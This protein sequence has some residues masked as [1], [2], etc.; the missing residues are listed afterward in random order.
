MVYD[1]NVT[2]YSCIDNRDNNDH[3]FPLL[4]KSERTIVSIAFC[5]NF[6]YHTFC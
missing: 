1:S 2:K 6:L 4:V 3:Y 5:P